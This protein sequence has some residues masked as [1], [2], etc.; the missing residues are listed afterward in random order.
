MCCLSKTAVGQ[1]DLKGLFQ[2]KQVYDSVNAGFQANLSLNF[3]GEHLKQSSV[4]G[5]HVCIHPVLNQMLITEKFIICSLMYVRWEH[6]WLQIPS[7]I[8]SCENDFSPS[9]LYEK[10]ALYF[11]HVS[12]SVFTGSGW[13]QEQDYAGWKM[14]HQGSC[15]FP[16]CLQPWFVLQLYFHPQM[17]AF[18]RMHTEAAWSHLEESNDCKEKFSHQH[19]CKESWDI[20]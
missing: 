17:S 6:T 7:K 11:P 12:D 2:A 5:R 13:S 8:G 10:E 19:R 9:E 18:A 16:H 4:L 20:L 15:K 14:L 3:P 1:D